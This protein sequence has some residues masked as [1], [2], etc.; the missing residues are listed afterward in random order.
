LQSAVS[1]SPAPGPS[2]QSSEARRLT[3]LSLLV[4]AGLG[5]SRQCRAETALDKEKRDVVQ[6]AEAAL[7]AKTVEE[8]E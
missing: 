7:G 6:M 3:F 2:L 1:T 4:G 5:G 8:E